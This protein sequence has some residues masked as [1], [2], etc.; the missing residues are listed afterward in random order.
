MAAIHA[1]YST[2]KKS[3]F[4]EIPEMLQSPLLLT[5]DPTLSQGSFDMKVI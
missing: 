4:S 2:K 5:I 3:L 1:F